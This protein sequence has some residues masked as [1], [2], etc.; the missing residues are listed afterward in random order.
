MIEVSSI[1]SIAES[2]GGRLITGVAV[3][4][5]LAML[6]AIVLRVC[7]NSSTKFAI[8]FL[9]LV[10]VAAFP[11]A[12]CFV[13]GHASNLYPT[14][15]ISVS[16]RWAFSIF[17]IWI[18]G[19]AIGLC[20]IALGL[21]RVRTIR[22]RCIEL[23]P[24]SI[25]ASS[26][27]DN[28]DFVLR[29]ALAEY[30]GSRR[31]SLCVSEDMTVPTAAGFF[32]PA[33]LLPAWTLKDLSTAELNSIVL[34]ELGHLHRWDD[35]TNLTQKVFKALLFFHPAVWWIDSR[36]ALER[37]IACDDFVLAKTSDAQGYANCLVSVAEKSVSRRALAMAVAAVGRFRQTATRLTRI[38]DQ[39]RLGGTRVSKP[40]FACMTVLASV[41]AIGLPRI[42]AIV[43]FGDTRPPLTTVASE[44]H[45]A[46]M[47]HAEQ[48]PEV[49]RA[50][51][52]VVSGRSENSAAPI[53]KKAELRTRGA[54]HFA[55]GRKSPNELRL[56]RITT[57]NSRPT[58]MLVETS[59][60]EERVQPTFL[61]MTQTVVCDEA[62]NCFVSVSAWR[63]AT[64]QQAQPTQSQTG[65]GP[66]SI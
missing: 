35:W 39:N 4:V 32:R 59:W 50:S 26:P 31:V 55:R 58:P 61:L 36:L 54:Q 40:A 23:D 5:L 6:A 65:S 15:H 16:G 49:I 60:T 56:T 63:V 18:V 3:G 2:L 29:S 44:A 41:F 11:L 57:N 38:L 19:A 21:L 48:V 53:L 42:P 43:V 45:V 24:N 9:T 51:A 12:A 30:G 47:G 7:R 66:K 62:G 1:Q 28:A 46:T 20:R 34:H 64:V 10:A 52:R 27:A 22:R 37:E 33:V 8:S 17:V 25:S 14:P 13:G